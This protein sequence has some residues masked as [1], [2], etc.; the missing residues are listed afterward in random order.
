MADNAARSRKTESWRAEAGLQPLQLS[1]VHVVY[2][3]E[4]VA[5]E[6][7]T[8]SQFPV[9]VDAQALLITAVSPPLFTTHFEHVSIPEVKV[10]EGQAL[11]AVPT[12]HAIAWAEAT[13]T[14]AK[15]AT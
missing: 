10:C 1:V 4:T 9:T 14:V 6:F 2:V 11:T 12:L 3:P 15:M 8:I 13:R 7:F 5:H